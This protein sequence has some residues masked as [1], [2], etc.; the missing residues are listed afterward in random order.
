VRQGGEGLGVKGRAHARVDGSGGAR[1]SAW[2]KGGGELSGA[3]GH[4]AEERRKER[5]R[6]RKKKREKEKGKRKRER[7][8]DSRRRPKPV[9]HARRSGVTR[10]TRAN[11]E[12]GRR[13]IRMSGSGFSE[14]REIGQEK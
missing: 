13:W 10:G 4:A 8:R 14:D 2:G 3:R 11:R 1:G 12:T 6:G 5:E 9:A 7:E